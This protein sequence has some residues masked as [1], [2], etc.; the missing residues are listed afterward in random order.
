MHILHHKIASHS[1][2][3]LSAADDL[4]LHVMEASGRNLHVDVPSRWITLWLPLSGS[5]EM[6]TAQSAWTLHRRSLLVWRDQALRAS[7]LRDCRL[8]GVGGA[9]AAWNPRLRI[10]EAGVRRD[11]GIFLQEEPCPRSLLRLLVRSVRM[12]RRSAT[13]ANAEDSVAALIAE[14]VVHQSGLHALLDRCSGRTRQR[15]QQTLSRLLR[16]RHLI[17]T[18]ENARLD[19]AQLAA[20]ANYSP[21]HL[22][23]SYRE[24][25][26]ET[27]SEHA[28]RLRSELALKLVLETRMPVCEITEA[29]GFE[30]QSAFCRAFKSIYGMT[31]S[32][33][34]QR[35]NDDPGF[36]SRAA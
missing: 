21:C 7:G 34:R 14:L 12:S 16:V 36:A 18:H 31:T 13:A 28:I 3:D 5:A 6:E 25:F 32:E 35:L 27:P 2:L 24:V 33:A 10:E 30:S 23:R 20:S 1:Q 15:R 4:S 11:A 22:I 8:L 26:G 17:R 19:L 29:V 9:A